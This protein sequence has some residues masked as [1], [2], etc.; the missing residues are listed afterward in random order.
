MRQKAQRRQR[1]STVTSGPK[2]VHCG[3]RKELLIELKAMGSH[4]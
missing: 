4:W 1:E 2:I 3:P